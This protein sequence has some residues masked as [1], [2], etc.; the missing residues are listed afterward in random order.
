[1][2]ENNDILSLFRN[3]KCVNVCAP[4]VRY[5]KLAFRSLVRK[6]ECDLCFTPMIIAESFLASPKARSSEFST[7]KGDRPLVVQFAANNADDFARAAELVA[8]Y[9]DGVDLNCGCPQ[10]WAMKEGYGADL[11]ARPECIRDM[12]LAVRNRVPRP[13]S[14]SAKLRLLPDL[15]RTV[16]LCRSLE[17]AGV[18]FLTVHARTPD[19]RHQPVDVAALRQLRESV[20]LPL[21]ANG[22]VRSLQGASRLQEATG[23]QG[24]M[25]A[26]GLLANPALFSGQPRTP[27]DCVRRWVGLAARTGASYQSLHHHLVFMLEKVL[28]RDQRLRFNALKRRDQVLD[29]LQDEL[30]VEVCGAPPEEAPEECSY[31]EGSYFAQ[32]VCRA[33]S[34]P[35]A[36]DYLDGACCLYA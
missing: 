20:A 7:N 10:R 13:L 33:R 8:P 16:E 18:S 31:S 14:V 36:E 22:D 9:C 4:M 35:P 34:P 32:A 30:G 28:G 3:K 6:Y 26:R 27:L 5:S 12:V 15:R 25:S 23:C 21:V 1:M 19:Q 17:R 24:V 2:H 11:L 29:F